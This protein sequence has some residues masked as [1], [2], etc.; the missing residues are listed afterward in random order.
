MD[1]TKITI[2]DRLDKRSHP[3]VVDLLS[4]GGHWAQDD[5]GP[6]DF[7]QKLSKYVGKDDLWLDL[8]VES[9]TKDFVKW[10]RDNEVIYINAAYEN[11]PENLETD[12]LSELGLYSDWMKIMQLIEKSAP[13]QGATSVIGCGANPG[14]VYHFAKQGLE[15]LANA[16]LKKEP[17]DEKRNEI[18][19]QSLKEEN[20]GV[21]CQT[22]GVKVIHISEK[23]SQITSLP[24]RQN[25]FVN[26]WSCC[27]MFDENIIPAEL[28]FGT[29]EKKLPDNAILH[30]DDGPKHLISLKTM[31]MNTFVRSW[32]PD[33]EIRGRILPHEENFHLGL[34]F[35]IRNDKKELVYRPTINYAYCPCESAQASMEEARNN[36]F[37][38][39]DH[40]RILGDEIISGR[41]CLGVLIMGHDF[42]SW[43]IGSMLD[44]TETRTLVGPRNNATTMQVAT[45]VMGAVAWAVRN[46][47]CG[48]ISCY[49]IP[50]HEMLDLTKPFLGPWASRAVDWNPLKSIAKEKSHLYIP[51][52]NYNATEE[53][54]WQFSTF[55]SH[56]C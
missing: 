23:D 1:Y 9:G 28:V 55:L 2:V 49:K 17:A 34:G 16:V 15:D 39:Q 31:G 36:N 14:L 35:E 56:S 45:G 32:T 27:G 21:L 37:V 26:T 19:R 53:D 40:Q 18:I 33:G 13:N 51:R 48:I 10:A 42:E 38:M 20:W 11:W 46:P 43:W 25:E 5:F 54:K 50:H 29:H 30:T 52:D 6:K 47:R 12:D 3:V 44:I 22:L 7:G 24:R 41:D 8:T 4:K